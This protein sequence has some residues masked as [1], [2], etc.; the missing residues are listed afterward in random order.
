MLCEKPLATSVR[1]CERMIEACER[2]DV[3]LM[4]AYRL[5]FER[6]NLEV[7]EMVRRKRIGEARYFDSQFS[8]Q[9]KSGNIRTQSQLGGGPEWDI[10][11]Y[12][13]N[14]ARY[15]FADEP[16]QVWA[17]ATNSGDRAVCGDSRDRARHHEISRRAHREL[18]LQLRRP[19]SLALRDRRHQGQRR[20]ST[21]RTNTPRGWVT[22][23]RSER[24]RKGRN[25][26][27]ATSSRPS[28]SISPSACGKAG[29]RSPR[30][31]KV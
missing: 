26:R 25:S 18:H 23:S 30:A 11:I 4:T 13:Q 29:R 6:C 16:T 8:M 1:D 22:S 17:T 14:A 31:R 21:P 2:N 3:R 19:R 15:V 10:G 7:A 24:R 9:V 12:C 20:V 28:S 5:H 27:R